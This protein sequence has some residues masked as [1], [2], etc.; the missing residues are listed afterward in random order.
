MQMMQERD[1]AICLL[2]AREVARIKTVFAASRQAT[3]FD[4]REMEYQH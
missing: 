4:H 1:E 3:E 2:E